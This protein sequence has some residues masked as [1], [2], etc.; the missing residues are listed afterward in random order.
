MEDRNFLKPVSDLWYKMKE[1]TSFLLSFYEEKNYEKSRDEMVLTYLIFFDE[2]RFK[3]KQ[4][5]R[6]LIYDA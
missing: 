2:I 1:Y 6:V 5:H 4:G 3:P